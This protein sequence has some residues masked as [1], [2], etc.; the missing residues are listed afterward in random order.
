MPDSRRS[1]LSLPALRAVLWPPTLRIRRA[2]TPLRRGALQLFSSSI[3]CFDVLDCSE[4]STISL[5]NSWCPLR[6]YVAAYPRIGLAGKTPPQLSLRGFAL[7]TVGTSVAFNSKADI[8][9]EGS[10]GWGRGGTVFVCTQFS[11][12]VLSRYVVL[13]H[14]LRSRWFAFFRCFALIA[15]LASVSA[16]RML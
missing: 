12:S 14:I 4:Q 2:L 10:S 8:S 16:R 6:I 3:L 5:G 1:T 11:Q 7:V 13:I 9:S 15:P